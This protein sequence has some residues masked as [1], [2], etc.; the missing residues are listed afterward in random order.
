M[1][2]KITARLVLI[3]GSLFY[4]S[5]VVELFAGYP[6]PP[7]RAF[8]SELA[9]RDQPTSGLVRTT[10]VLA[11][12]SFFAAGLLLIPAH[13]KRIE[14]TSTRS[15][16][17]KKS[18][19]SQSR[20]PFLAVYGQVLVIIG[21]GITGI[22]TVLDSVFPLDCAEVGRQCAVQVAAGAVSLP[23]HIHVITSSA[24]GVGIMVVAAG[25]LAVGC[26][27]QQALTITLRV[28]AV[29]VVL[30]VAA[31]LVAIACGWPVGVAQRLQVVLTV[32]MFIVMAFPLTSS[33]LAPSQEH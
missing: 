14:G 26:Q 11:G 22:A 27:R 24:A 32:V 16:F 33:D 29:G 8:L 20:A 21:L 9:A 31:Q 2:R 7:T 10:D 19:R 25:C 1:A 13:L 23:H 3:V 17:R 18:S 30:T 15:S 28:I 6:L 12:L 4:S 5:F